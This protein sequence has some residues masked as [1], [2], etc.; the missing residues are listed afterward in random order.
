VEPP[1]EEVIRRRAVELL[2]IAQT[3]LTYARDVFDRQRY[4]QVQHAATALLEL[5]SDGD[6]Q[7]LRRI[8]AA[9]AGHATPKVDVRGALFDAH[10]RVLLVQDRSDARWTLPGGWCD[11]LETPS[12]AV[13]REVREES[14]ISVRVLG[15]AAVLDR[16]RQGHQPPLPVHVY[17]LFFLCE[18]QAHGEPDPTE[19]LDVGWFSLDA[20]PELSHTRVTEAELRIAYSRYRDPTLPAEFD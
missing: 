5:V 7:A 20:L 10:D 3:G 11:V 9:D 4:G 2:A 19:T 15:L 16:E 8:V 12:E 1:A 13:R 17:K 14:G 18:A 6:P